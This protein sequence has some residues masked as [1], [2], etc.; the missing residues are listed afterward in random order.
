M[1]FQTRSSLHSDPIGVGI[2]K[3]LPEMTKGHHQAYIE[4]ILLQMVLPAKEPV[5]SDAYPHEDISEWFPQIHDQAREQLLF[6]PRRAGA[7][8][9]LQYVEVHGV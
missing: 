6:D 1:H 7:V 5:V 4:T 3:G 8:P 9:W 2:I